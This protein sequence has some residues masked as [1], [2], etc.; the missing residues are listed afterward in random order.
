LKIQ[1]P[2]ERPL[3]KEV[4]KAVVVPEKKPIPVEERKPRAIPSPQNLDLDMTLAKDTQTLVD[5]SPVRSVQPKSTQTIQVA[6][7]DLDMEIVNRHPPGRT[8]PASVMSAPSKSA[9][10]TASQTADYLSVPMDIAPKE[11]TAKGT[12]QGKNRGAKTGSCNPV[13]SARAPVASLDHLS[14]TLETSDKPR[15][16]SGPGGS[17]VFGGQSTARGG[18]S[19]AKLLSMNTKSLGGIEVPVGLI[20]GEGFGTGMGTGMGRHASPSSGHDAT[21]VRMIQHKA[22]GQIAL[23]TPLAFRLADVN[24]ETLSGS[25]YLSRSTQLKRFLEKQMLPSAPVTI[26][27]GTDISNATGAQDLVAISY[28]STQIILQFENGKQQVITFVVGEPY[29]RFELRL[30]SS[31]SQRLVAGTKLEEITS[32]LQTLQHIMKE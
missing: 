1:K 19:S 30:A 7:I 15:G 14:M 26:S 3:P 16:L 32:C 24:E 11:S 9:G 28:S 23:G 8:S 25:A 31:G 21:P 22:I 27:M 10:I 18:N 6:G 2:L 13:L 4:K 17:G 29:P 20:G 12:S 5:T